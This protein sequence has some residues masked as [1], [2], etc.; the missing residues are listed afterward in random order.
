MPVAFF[1]WSS[2]PCAKCYILVRG[3][4]V[5]RR[6]GQ[7]R[8]C[9]PGRSRASCW[10]CPHQGWSLKKGDVHVCKWGRVG[11]EIT[12]SA[13]CCCISE[14]SLWFK[15]D[16]SV[17]QGSLVSGPWKE[18]NWTWMKTSCLWGSLKSWKMC[19]WYWKD[20]Y[21]ITSRVC[22]VSTKTQVTV[23]TCFPVSSVSQLEKDPGNAGVE[24]SLLLRKVSA[25]GSLS[26]VRAIRCECPTLEPQAQTYSCRVSKVGGSIFPAFGTWNWY[27]VHQPCCWWACCWGELMCRL[28]ISGVHWWKREAVKGPSCNEVSLTLFPVDKSTLANKILAN[29]IDRAANWKYNYDF[30]LA[31]AGVSK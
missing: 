3:I 14:V 2:K 10:R 7:G 30:I 16:C 23:S 31:S 22:S 20:F 9:R 5:R 26:K 1:Q 6:W 13:C 29:R 17:H 11:Q 18:Q 28:C 27:Y 21:L 15:N 12:L 25:P 8:G 19:C 24:S 4:A